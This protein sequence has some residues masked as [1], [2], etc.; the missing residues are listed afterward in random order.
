MNFLDEQVK[1]NPGFLDQGVVYEE[2]FVRS[3][4]FDEESVLEKGETVEQAK[5]RIC[6]LYTSDAADE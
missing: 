6:L 4:N 5:A 1:V 3:P 2:P